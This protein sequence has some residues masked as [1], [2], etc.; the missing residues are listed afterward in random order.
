MGGRRSDRYRVCLAV[1]YERAAEFV[2]EYAENLSAGGLFVAGAIDL[3]PLDEVL[4]EIDLPGL[5][6]FRVQMEVAHVL[7]VAT[8]Q[9][10]GRTAGAGMSIRKA[11]PDFE[12]A[13]GTYLQRLGNRADHLVLVESA[14]LRQALGEAGYGVDKAPDPGGLVTT[15]A[16]LEQP[17]LRVVVGSSGAAYYRDAAR[18]AGDDEL[19]LVWD[20]PSDLDGVLTQLDALL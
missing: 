18:T 17:V 7:D 15:I 6:V 9:R 10:L 14:P 20:D 8:A 2:R 12:R 3:Q 4:V 5:G 16:R 19:I 11:P 13:L 1:R